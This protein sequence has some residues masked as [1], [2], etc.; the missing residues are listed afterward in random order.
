MSNDHHKDLNLW[1]SYTKSIKPLHKSENKTASSNTNNIKSLPI[2][3]KVITQK[4]TAPY[5]PNYTPKPQQIT[6]NPIEKHLF[7]ANIN[8]KKKMKKGAFIYDVKIDL[9]GMTQNQAFDALKEFIIDNHQ[10]NRRHLLIIT[11]RGRFCYKNFTSSG[12]L[13]KKVPEWLK[14]PPFSKIVTVIEQAS[15]YDGSEGALYVILKK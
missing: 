13:L 3:N 14:E 15:V 11:G 5:D 1:K 10:N 7:K 9:H 12:I 2:N 4:K 8:T 6:I